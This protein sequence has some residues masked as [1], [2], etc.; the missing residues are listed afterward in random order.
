MEKPDIIFYDRWGNIKQPGKDDIVRDRT[1]AFAITIAKGHLL[2]TWQSHAPEVPELPGGGVDDGEDTWTAMTREFYE[3]AGINLTVPE[4][5][6][7]YKQYIG[8]YADDLN[9][10]W[11]YTQSYFLLQGTD[12]DLLFFSGEKRSPEDGKVMWIDLADTKTMPI[13]YCHSLALQ[14]CTYQ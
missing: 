5:A 14:N 2:L 11:R 12:I 4:S 13:H 10:Y 8:Y 1:G 7:A 6:I 3:E 9:E